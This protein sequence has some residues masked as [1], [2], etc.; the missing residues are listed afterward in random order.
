M[1]DVTFRSYE[2]PGGTSISDGAA[3]RPTLTL[4]VTA[5]GRNIGGGETGTANRPVQVTLHGPGDVNGLRPGAIV[6]TYPRDR[7]TDV[8][9]SF[10]PW[11]EFAAPDLAWRYSPTPPAAGDV[12]PWMALLVV[13]P[14]EVTS[15]PRGTIVTP[16]ALAAQRPTSEW[17]LDPGAGHVQGAANDPAATCRIVCRRLL[18]PDT[19][20][21]ALL[22]PAFDA[23]GRERWANGSPGPLPVYH[24]W[25]FR[26]GAGGDFASLAIKLRAANDQ[27]QIGRLHVEWSDGDPVPVRGALTGIQLVAD[28]PVSD[29]VR[30]EFAEL[31]TFDPDQAGGPDQPGEGFDEDGRRYVRPPTYGRAWTGVDI[32]DAP[33]GGWYADVNRHPAHRVVAGLGRRSAVELQEEIA[34]ATAGR[35][36]G[37]GIANQR[38]AALS[39]G[40]AVTHRLWTRLPDD[41]AA[42]IGILGVAAGAILTDDGAGSGPRSL[43]SRVSGTDRTL[44]P[45]LF[46][47]AARRILRSAARRASDARSRP[48]PSSPPP[49]NRESLSLMS[50]TTSSGRSRTTWPKREKAAGT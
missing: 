42:R 4:D 33:R 7:Q 6:G 9:T 22:V 27:D 5:T 28:D 19:D 45:G 48:R 31:I 8:E 49:T 17:A 30:N 11:V 24:Q 47:T 2:R 3:G 32:G 44:P 38:L 1:S 35:L 10:C 15:T 26:T 13:K 36:G 40:L 20:Y 14:E 12:I 50:T 43:L 34:T 21:R 29:A 39:L 16:T 37:V 23:D 46:S 25:R 41:P 18:E